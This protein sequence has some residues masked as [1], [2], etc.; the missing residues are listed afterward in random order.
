MAAARNTTQT[1]F[2]EELSALQ[3]T[4]RFRLVALADPSGLAWAVSGDVSV[5]DHLASVPA[6][7]A[8][9]FADRQP[10]LRFFS[11]TTMR[12]EYHSDSLKFVQERLDGYAPGASYYLDVPSEKDNNEFI[13]SWADRQFVVIRDITVNGV[14]WSLLGIGS[15]VSAGRTAFRNG[16]AQIAAHIKTVGER[17]LVPT[18]GA[19][20]APLRDKMLMALTAFRDSTEGIRMTAV[21]SKDGFV[22]ASLGE[23]SMD[24]EMVAPLMGHSFLAIQESTQRLCGATETVMLRMEEGILLGRELSDGL[25]FAALLEPAAC[26]GQVLSTFELAGKALSHAL[27]SMSSGLQG[28]RDVEMAV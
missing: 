27:Q 9:A 14:H 3:A 23:S 7:L 22:V 26:T 15:D 25:L 8:R 17:G 6:M 16:A 24:P 5:P 11:Q 19:A 2:Q 10:L 1:S 12:F 20:D 13:L 28:A 21:T 18:A 4:G